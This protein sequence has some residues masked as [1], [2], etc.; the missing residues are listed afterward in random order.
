MADTGNTHTHTLEI[1]ITFL[2]PGH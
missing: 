1:V 2:C